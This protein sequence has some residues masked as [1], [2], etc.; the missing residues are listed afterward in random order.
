MLAMAIDS[1]EEKLF[2]LPMAHIAVL[3]YVATGQAESDAGVR[4]HDFQDFVLAAVAPEI[5]MDGYVHA[6][7]VLERWCDRT[8]VW[9]TLD[10]TR[11]KW[12]RK[13]HRCRR[14][15]AHL[16]ERGASTH[17]NVLMV[18]HGYPDPLVRQLPELAA[19][20]ESSIASLV[21]YTDAVEEH[22]QSLIAQRA[23]MEGAWEY[24]PTARRKWQWCERPSD[25]QVVSLDAFAERVRVLDAAISSSDAL[26]DALAPFAEPM[27]V[28]G[29]SEP[30]P[31]YQT[32][33]AERAERGRWHRAAVAARLFAARVEAQHTL[34]V[35]ESAYRDA[36][37][38]VGW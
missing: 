26:R 16:R 29:P 22:R 13:V 10:P 38:G 20:R 36:W 5:D 19:L 3:Q 21:R 27:P 4:C 25:A 1:N 33:L 7:H 31:V 14:A 28:Q 35:A 18:A 8:E 15:L 24:C 32:R 23:S 9:A 34:S 6:L 12:Q 2:R 17:A 11:P 30:Q 37:L